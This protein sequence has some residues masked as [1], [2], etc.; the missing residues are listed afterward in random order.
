MV[1]PDPERRL[2]LLAGGAVPA[3]AALLNEPGSRTDG[4]PAQVE[5]ITDG[6]AEMAVRVSASG[7][8]Y[9]VLADAVQ[10]GW[11][12][13]IDGAPAT[14]VAADHAFAAVAVPPGVH[15]V[16]FSYDGA[17]RTAGVWVSVAT[18]LV[19]VLA[20][21]AAETVRRRR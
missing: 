7:A 5:W 16:R 14:I 8:G 6:L 10:T 15:V 21:V 4:Q 12:A 20:V 19:L 18:L 3:D 1:V 13:T 17:A 9:L 11:R 2:A